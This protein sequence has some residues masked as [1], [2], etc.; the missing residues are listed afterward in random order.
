MAADSVLEK[1]HG[2]GQIQSFTISD[3]VVGDKTTLDGK[4]KV[5]LEELSKDSK[6]LTRSL[7]SYLD[8]VAATKRSNYGS[9]SVRSTFD[10][11]LYV[12]GMPGYIVELEGTSSEAWSGTSPYNADS[13]NSAET[14]KYDT[15]NASGLSITA[16]SMGG[17]VSFSSGNFSASL[18]YPELTN[19]FNYYHSFSGIKAQTGVLGSITKYT[20]EHSTTMLFGNRTVTAVAS[21]STI[22]W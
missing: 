14:F 22:V 16:P 21:D 20:H 4:A 6:K 3:T 10:V 18:V 1:V 11:D 2:D 13:I 8:N 9:G 12:D 5:E 19:N 7:Y 15:F 17:G